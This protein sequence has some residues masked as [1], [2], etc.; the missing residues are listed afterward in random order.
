MGSVALEGFGSGGGASLN[1]KVVGNPQPTNPKGNTIWLNTDTKITGC[2]FQ[3]EKPEDMKPGEVW[4][5]TGTSSTVAFNALKKGTVMVYPI[6]AKQMGQDGMLVDVT[7][8]SWKNGEWVEWTIYL[9][10]DGDECEDITGGWKTAMAS[11][12]CTLTKEIASNGSMRMTA[13]SS[14]THRKGYFYTDNAIDLTSVNYVRCNITERS[15]TNTSNSCSLV[16][17]DAT[18]LG[19]HLAETSISAIGEIELNVTGVD[20]VGRVAFYL[21]GTSSGQSTTVGTDKVWLD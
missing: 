21:G 4:I 15:L 9:F 7:A 5:S 2:Y 14:A 10:N 20:G 18:T 19:T 16:I 3:S 11:D 1:F 17:C 6:Y 13:K 8:M 12:S